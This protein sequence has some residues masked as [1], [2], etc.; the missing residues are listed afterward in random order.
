MKKDLLLRFG[1]DAKTLYDKPKE[2]YGPITVAEAHNLFLRLGKAY[3][4]F[5]ENVSTPS[6]NNSTA[7]TN[8]NDEGIYSWNHERPAIL[9]SSTSWT[10]DED[11]GILLRAL[12]DYDNAASQEDNPQFPNLLCVITGKG[13][14]KED[15]KRRISKQVCKYVLIIVRICGNFLFPVFRSNNLLY[16][17]KIN[18]LF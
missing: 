16:I 14:Q 5:L 15:Y 7:F 13:P 11:F 17:N 6:K 12:Q 1:A 9:I 10:E 18:T 2:S 3:S 4:V 8:L